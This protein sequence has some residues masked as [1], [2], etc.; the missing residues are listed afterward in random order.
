MPG[1]PPGG[2]QQ[3]RPPAFDGPMTMAQILER[4]PAGGFDDLKIGGAVVVTS[5]RGA[6]PGKVTAIMIVANFDGLIQFAQSQAAAGANPMEALGRLH[7][8]MMGGPGGFSLPA[9]LP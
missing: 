8:G 5:T 3:H 4:L 2:G 7:G 9:M 1:G 6:T